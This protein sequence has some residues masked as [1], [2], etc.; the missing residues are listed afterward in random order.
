MQVAGEGEAVLSS[1][2]LG[3]FLAVGKAIGSRQRVKIAV[4]KVRAPA[5]V[6]GNAGV[7]FAA[8]VPPYLYRQ[9]IGNRS[10]AELPAVRRAL[11]GVEVGRRPACRAIRCLANR[12]TL[13]PALHERRELFLK[14]VGWHFSLRLPSNNR[15]ERDA[16][17]KSRRRAPQAKRS[18][19]RSTTTLHISKVIFILHLLIKGL[20]K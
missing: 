9:H 19:S 14:V 1:E 13:L 7:G 10:L 2:P 17:P 12:L 15:F 11:A 5:A 3:H 20:V 6:L 8:C 18:A 16:P 4:R